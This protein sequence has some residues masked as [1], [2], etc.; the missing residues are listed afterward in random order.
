MK[1]IYQEWKGGNEL[2]GWKTGYGSLLKG[3]LYAFPAIEY[4]YRQ[5]ILV[6]K[7]TKSERRRVQSLVSHSAQSRLVLRY[8][9]APVSTEAVLLSDF[10]SLRQTGVADAVP[11]P[12]AH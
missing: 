6:M 4:P 7:A 9:K 1:K 2:I 5:L 8:D 3:L 11:T 12:L 10:W